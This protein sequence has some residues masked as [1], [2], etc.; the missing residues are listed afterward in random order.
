MNTVN[1]VE[2]RVKKEIEEMNKLS[3]EEFCIMVLHRAKEILG[4]EAKK[5]D[6]DRMIKLC[7]FVAEDIG[8]PLTRGWYKSF[9]I[10]ASIIWSRERWEICLKE[11]NGDLKGARKLYDED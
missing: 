4:E 11:A 8:Y 1:M 2:Q 3:E 10:E 9:R 6:T 5:L 7:C